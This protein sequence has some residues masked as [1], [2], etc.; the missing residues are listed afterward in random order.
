[1]KKYNVLY[2]SDSRFFCHMLTSIY[3]LLK[4]NKNKDIVIHI[5]E[6]GF[7]EYQKKLLYELEKNYSCNII[8]YSMDD[9]ISVINKYNVPKWRGTD[10]ANARLFA[11]E[12]IKNLENLL[13]IDSDTIIVDS[14]E[15]LFNIKMNNPV[16][17]VKELFIPS[18]M[19]G[20]LSKY[21]NSGVILFDYDM[22][23]RDNCM[24]LLYSCLEKNRDILFYPDQDLLN[25]ALEGRIKENIPIFF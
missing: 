9:F 15:E 11:C 1:M 6:Y 20:I 17:A 10:I 16:G 23:E 21:Y 14:I 13:Y 2:T 7:T 4:N 3:S 18:H 25:M 5:I 12:F 22:W 8:L 19:D 24:N